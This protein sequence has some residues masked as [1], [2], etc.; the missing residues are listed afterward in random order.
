MIPSLIRWNSQGYITIEGILDKINVEANHGHAF[1]VTSR[2]WFII[3]SLQVSFCWVPTP[4]PIFWIVFPCL[5]LIPNTQTPSLAS[6]YHPPPVAKKINQL[7]TQHPTTFGQLEVFDKQKTKK[8][9]SQGPKSWKFPL[10][11][12]SMESVVATILK[13]AARFD[14][15]W[16][17]YI[18]VSNCIYIY[19]K[20]YMYSAI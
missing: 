12:R 13:N 5:S 10:F 16:C 2:S 17:V 4:S 9:S 14:R 15:N 18:Y 6:R 20:M 3:L 8:Y 7:P 11:F 1:I 19:I